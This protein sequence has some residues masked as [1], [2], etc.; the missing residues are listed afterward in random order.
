MRPT[1]SD[2]RAKL[3]R[4]DAAARLGRARPRISDPRRP[5]TYMPIS[6]KRFR[7]EFMLRPLQATVGGTAAR[8]PCR[9][10]RGADQPRTPQ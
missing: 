4:Q 5:V 1:S 3:W 8:R 9:A 10:A 2:R 7:W 6:G